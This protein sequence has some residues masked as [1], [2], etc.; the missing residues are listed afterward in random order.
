L[1]W[2]GSLAGVGVSAAGFALVLRRLGQLEQAV[3]GARAEALAARLAA[4]RADVRLAAAQRALTDSL[5]Y[6][7]EEAFSRSDAAAVWRELDGPL[8]QAQRYW[9]VLVGG[10]VG[11]PLLLDPRFTLQEAAAAHEA[12]LA[13]AAARVQALLLLEEKAAALHHARELQRWHEQTVAGLSPPDVAAVRARAL[14][15][16][17]GVSLEDARARLLRLAEGFKESVLE[18]QLQAATRP[19]LLEAL[20]ERG[21]G[22]REHVEAVRER[23]DVPV[24]TLPLP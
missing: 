13:L 20:A 6:R 8:D 10:G 16:A 11:A 12:V 24:L 4:E 23:R 5:L 19:G 7:A 22:G 14:A 9:R 3:A 15:E 18:A 2:G 1:T 17:E 21:W